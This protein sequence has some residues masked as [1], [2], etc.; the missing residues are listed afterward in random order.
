MLAPTIQPPTTT[1]G[2]RS[3]IPLSIPQ[4]Y[5]ISVVDAALGTHF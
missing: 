3:G 2:A 1:T 5:T 4:E